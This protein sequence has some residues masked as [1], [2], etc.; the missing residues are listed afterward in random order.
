MPWSAVAS[1]GAAVIGGVASNRAANKAAEA[2]DR[3]LAANAWQGQIASDQYADYKSTYRPLEQQLAQR[4]QEA[5]SPLAYQKAT[6]EA[7]AAVSSQ[8]AAAK[9]RL[10]RTPGFDPTSA[11]AQTA[12]AN[13]E[14]KGAALGATEQNR[15]RQSVE[16][17]AWA[18]K[19]DVAGIGKGL[20]AGAST[21]L[22]SASAGAQALAHSAAQDSAQT[23]SGMGAMVSG[24]VNGLSK[25]DWG[26]WGIGSNSSANSS[27]S[28]NPG[29]S[30][31][32]LNATGS[33]VWQQAP[34][35]A[36]GYPDGRGGG[37]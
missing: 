17:K 22:A 1:I 11:A 20:I 26:R 28:A 33:P 23:A 27:T 30:G 37:V 7:Q 2:N 15:A 9:E 25:V 21:G 16:D 29:Y 6:S 12:L 4:A 18:R 31:V 8:L 34:A 5:D 14:L 35:G 19:L 36:S 10:A 3:A 32:P 24:V 13:L